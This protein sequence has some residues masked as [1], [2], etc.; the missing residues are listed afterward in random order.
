MTL[1][2]NVRTYFGPLKAVILDWSGTVSDKYVLAPA[3]VFKEVFQKHGIDVSM[4]DC[5]K[6]MGLRKDLH[7][8]VML[9]GNSSIRKKW[10]QKFGK[11]PDEKDVDMLFKDFVPMQLACLPKYATLIPGAAET[12][13]TL[14]D[15]YNVKIGSTTGFTRPMVDILEKEANKQGAFFDCTVAG[16]EVAT[17]FRPTPHMVY[18]NL[19]LLG[20][21][22]PIS[23]VV[24]VDDTVGGIGEGINA[25]CWT[26]G[27][28]RYSNYMDIDSLEHEKNLTTPA[29]IA[30]NQYSRKRLLEA[31]AHY[32]VDTIKELPIVMDD[33]NEKLSKGEY[34]Q[35][36]PFVGA[37]FEVPL[38]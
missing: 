26:V 16:D 2:R 8:K 22:Q 15:E 10:Q 21:T 37:F 30:R 38:L 11:A 19:D 27:V 31:G 29:L 28:S 35:T 3:V 34:P 17:G 6:P 1:L 14:R 36:Q 32:V 5:R 13:H 23:S 33:I 18:K 25:G 7:I 20:L 4:A 24:K 12:I 9:L